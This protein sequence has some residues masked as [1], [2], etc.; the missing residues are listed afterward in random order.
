MAQQPQRPQ[1]PQGSVILWALWVLVGVTAAFFLVSKALDSVTASG[2]FAP[3]SAIVVAPAPVPASDT[4]ATAPT[5]AAPEPPSPKTAMAKAPA[6]PPAAAGVTSVASRAEGSVRT[7]EIA[8]RTPDG[9]ALRFDARRFV[10]LNFERRGAL[11]A[12]AAPIASA[13]SRSADRVSGPTRIA[14]RRLLTRGPSERL[15]AEALARR[16]GIGG[17][18]I[19]ECDAVAARI[20]GVADATAHYVRCGA[21]GFEPVAASDWTQLV[22]AH[23]RGR[24]AGVAIL[25]KG[26]STPPAALTAMRSAVNGGDRCNGDGASARGRLLGAI[27]AP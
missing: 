4:A 9:G 11:C 21:G 10:V 26:L 15:E 24:N 13:W 14:E 22:S 5:I 18:A 23:N 17:A 2:F 20:D 8:W 27:G 3:R 7:Y 19:E 1:Q 12:V 6:P 16:L 25:A